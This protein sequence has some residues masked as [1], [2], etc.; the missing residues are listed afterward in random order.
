MGQSTSTRLFRTIPPERMG[1]DGEYDHTG[2]TKR[3]ELAL[4]QQ[5][6]ATEVAR[7]RVTQRGA[8]VVLVGKIADQRSLIR[9]VAVVMGV[10]GAA[11]L[12][13]NGVSVA[14]P[15][16]FYLHVKPSKAALVNLLS[17]INSDRV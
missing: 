7:W 12:E 6:S 5:F 4:V 9:L 17:S 1:V 3:V 13:I 10:S 8:V 16:R 15:L 2:L 14:E 11:D